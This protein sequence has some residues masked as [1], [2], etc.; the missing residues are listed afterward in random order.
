MTARLVERVRAFEAIAGY[1]TQER[2]REVAESFATEI[3]PNAKAAADGPRT[4]MA[5]DEEPKIDTPGP[6]VVFLKNRGLQDVELVRATAV[7]SER[8]R[9][10]RSK[11]PQFIPASDDVLAEL[12]RAA[13]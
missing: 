13:A 5:L 10:H 9:V 1:L 3:A 2:C 12:W 8:L 6:V 7:L 4:P 11:S